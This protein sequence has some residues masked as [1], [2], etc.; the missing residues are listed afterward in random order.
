MKKVAFFLIFISSLFAGSEVGKVSQ[1]MVHV[2]DIVMFELS[3][4]HADKPTDC[5]YPAGEG[6]AFS[7]NEE[8]GKG[9]LSMLLTAAAQGKEIGIQGSGNCSAWGDRENPTYMYI[10]Y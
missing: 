2:G 3:G 4:T 1:V 7:L 10:N 8:R 6:W 9:M 5:D